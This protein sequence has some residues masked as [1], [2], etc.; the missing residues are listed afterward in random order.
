[1]HVGAHPHTCLQTFTWMI[2]GDV[3]HRDSLGNEQLI[4]PGEVNLM[5][6]GRGISHTE[7]STDA[8]D[9]LH[10][11]QLWI[12]LPPH[13][14]DAE[15]AFTHYPDLPR[16]QQKGIDFTLL[17]GEFAGQ[18]S[19]VEVYSPLLGLDIHSPSG[20]SCELS[21]NPAFEHGLL[22]MEGELE[23]NG[24]HFAENELAALDPGTSIL[25]LT[26]TPGSRLIL[27]GGEPAE[28][29]L[30]FWNFVGYSREYIIEATQEWQAEAARFGKVV[31][32]DGE[33]LAAQALP[34][35][36]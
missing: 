8:T 3:L 18:T 4:R 24:A 5:T 2:E 12:A 11:A 28:K 9:R 31:G 33:R 16:W 15:P 25:H 6:A 14:A 35:W 22:V 10:A 13:M 30:M 19:P 32:F 17:V 36:V 23:F 21:L 34:V 29:V 26:L 1:M 7:D 27:I 20:G